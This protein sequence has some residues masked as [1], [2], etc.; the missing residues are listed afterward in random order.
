[1]STDYRYGK[2]ITLLELIEEC[3]LEQKMSE[4][5][6]EKGKE[7]DCKGERSKDS[8]MEKPDL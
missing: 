2:E 8:K 6:G 4:N 3:E 5:E 7:R 1:M